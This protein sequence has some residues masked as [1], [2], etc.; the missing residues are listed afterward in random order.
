MADQIDQDQVEHVANLAKLKLNDEELKTV[1]PQ[2]EQIINLFD[3]LASVDTQ[4]VQP[5]YSVTDQVNVMREDIAADS[6]QRNELLAN[7]PETDDGY[8]R[9]PAII[10]ESGDEAQ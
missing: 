2:L 7:A 4:D 1:T 5:T 6:Y 9:V 10:D 8:I 3:T